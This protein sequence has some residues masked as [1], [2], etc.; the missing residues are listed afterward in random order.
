MACTGYPDCKTTRQLT[1]AKASA[2]I[3]LEEKCPKC[4]RNLVL[5]TGRF[6]E[7]V[8][9]SGYPKCKWVKQ[10]FIGVTC[11]KCGE[12]EVA[13]KKARRGNLFYGCS[14]YPKCDFTSAYKPVAEP[15]PQCGSSYLVQKDLK[16][17]TVL[18]CPNNKKSADVDE[19]PKRGKKKAEEATAVKCDY[20]RPA[21]ELTPVAV[22]QAPPP[23]ASTEEASQVVQ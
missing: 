22:E 13:E 1:Q 19:K 7:F 23:P 4:D 14:E 15:C 20:S 3:P 8:A 18:M 11:P 12:G 16:S 21:P 2:P 6:G 5:R 17:G 9:C 10:N